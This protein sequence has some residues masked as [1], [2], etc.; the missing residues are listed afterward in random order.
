MSYFKLASETIQLKEQG[1]DI[2]I[3]SIVRDQEYPNDQ[4]VNRLRNLRK[5]FP[6]YQR[7]CS[8]GLF[9]A[10]SGLGSAFL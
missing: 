2:A 3:S 10:C 1:Q 7:Y 8:D 9:P 4:A 5:F 6:Q